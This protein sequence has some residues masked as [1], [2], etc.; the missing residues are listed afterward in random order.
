MRRR[1]CREIYEFFS[2][3]HTKTYGKNGKRITYK[4]KFIDS[5]RL[6]SSSLSSIVDNLSEGLHKKKDWMAASLKDFIIRI[7]NKHINKFIL[8]WRKGIFPYAYMYSWKRSDETLLSNKE[9]FYTSL[10][11]IDVD[12]RHAIKCIKIYSK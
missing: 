10:N 6:V 3:G 1:K 12:H 8:L 9:D 11:I 7:C 5:F 2:T 4:I